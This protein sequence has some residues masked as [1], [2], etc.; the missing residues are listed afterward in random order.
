MF[1]IWTTQKFYT[2][3]CN[4]KYYGEETREKMILV[5]HIIKEDICN[6][7]TEKKAYYWDESKGFNVS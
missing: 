3:E 4:R 6:V 5:H 7:N 2:K 1:T